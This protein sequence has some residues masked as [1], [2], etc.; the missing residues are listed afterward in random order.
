MLVAA[1]MMPLGHTL[2]P[3]VSTALSGTQFHV[4]EA[5]LSASAGFGIYAIFG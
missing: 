1:V 5:V 3:Y 4:I 2:Y